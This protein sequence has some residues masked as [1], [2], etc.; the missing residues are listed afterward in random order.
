MHQ[1]GTHIEVDI[2]TFARMT[3]NER[4][5]DIFIVRDTVMIPGDRQFQKLASISDQCVSILLSS[6]AFVQK[7]AYYHLINIVAT[8]I[9]ISNNGYGLPISIM[10]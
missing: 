8:N 1:T 4:L 10:K 2:V 5:R 6:K 3:R 7:S 9:I